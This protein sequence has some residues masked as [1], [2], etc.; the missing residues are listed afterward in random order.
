[1]RS[2]E[3]CRYDRANRRRPIVTE[4]K[5]GFKIPVS[6][7]VLVSTSQ[8]EVL[9]ME[10]R[11]ISGYWQSVTGS[12]E[13]NESTRVA[14]QRELLEETGLRAPV[15][16][17]QRTERFTITPAWRMRYA[18]DV[19]ENIEHW[20]QL[21]LPKKVEVQLCAEEHSASVWLPC[22]DALALCSS[23]S[24]RAAIEQFA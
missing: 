19:T 24:N 6:V 13:P 23:D 17:L 22:T 12:L 5:Q 2:G 14:A 10:R 11:D 7:L 18:P 9:L 1:M 21:V 20:F 3:S 16:D 15:T 4:A 8:H